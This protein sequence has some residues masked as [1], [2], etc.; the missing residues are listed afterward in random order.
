MQHLAVG[1]LCCGV[2]QP[3]ND[4]KDARLCGLLAELDQSII[5]LKE[6]GIDVESELLETTASAII[7]L[8]SSMPHYHP[9]NTVRV[10]LLLVLA[11]MTEWLEG[12]DDLFFSLQPWLRSIA[13]QQLRPP[14][15]SSTPLGLAGICDAV[16]TSSGA[17]VVAQMCYGEHWRPYY[18]AAICTVMRAGSNSCRSLLH[19]NDCPL[20]SL[21]SAGLQAS[22]SSS[23]EDREGGSSSDTAQQQS[24]AQASGSTAQGEDSQALRALRKAACKLFAARCDAATAAHSQASQWQQVQQSRLQLQVWDT[25]Y[26]HIIGLL[27]VGDGLLAVFS[28]LSRNTYLGSSMLK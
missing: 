2:L 9:V 15:L 6:D 1:H 5:E 24:Q 26:P 19:I 10:A 20:A 14:V 12:C 28:M 8:L 16:A 4:E 22:S 17:D 3:S 21:I 25:Y 7:K 23:G 13:L 27:Q 18:L 11:E